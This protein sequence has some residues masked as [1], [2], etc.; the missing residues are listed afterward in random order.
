METTYLIRVEKGGVLL[1]FRK[2]IL[3]FWHLRWHAGGKRGQGIIEKRDGWRDYETTSQ[4]FGQEIRLILIFKK[5]D[6]RKEPFCGDVM[7]IE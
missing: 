7:F 1:G 6:L 3:K 5:I 2:Y 4:T